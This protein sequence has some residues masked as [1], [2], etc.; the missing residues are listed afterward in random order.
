MNNN[1]HSVDELYQIMGLEPFNEFSAKQRNT[2]LSSSM[3]S[4]KECD[5]FRQ[6]GSTTRQ[7]C[8]AIAMAL[9]GKDVKYYVYNLNTLYQNLKL[10]ESMLDKLG[11]SWSPMKKGIKLGNTTIKF[12]C[13]STPKKVFF[14]PSF[15]DLY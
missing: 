14:E 15:N 1:F 4:R 8:K 10:T 5:G 13:F 9:S 3:H 12:K 11:F 2:N 6:T 7:L